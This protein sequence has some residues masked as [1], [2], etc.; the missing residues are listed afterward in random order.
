MAEFHDSPRLLYIDAYDSFA[1][2]IITFVKLRLN[3]SVE[4]I[5]IDDPRF[6]CE[7]QSYFQQYVQQFDAVIAGPGPGTPAKKEDIGLIS[8]LWILNDKSIVP[9]L[10]ICLG[11]QSLVLS[12]GGSVFRLPFPRHGV[13]TQ[14]VHSDRTI[15]KGIANIQA[16]LYNSLA[17]DLGHAR[18]RLQPLA[19][20]RVGNQAGLILSAVRHRDTQKPF[21]GLQFHPESACTNEA[22]A[23]IIQ[24][25]WREASEWNRT[26]RKTDVPRARIRDEAQESPCK[27]SGVTLSTQPTPKLPLSIRQ[28]SIPDASVTVDTLNGIA[29]SNECS[30][31]LLESVQR[32]PGVPIRTDTGRFTVAGFCNQ[33]TKRILYFT[34]TSQLEI[35]NGRDEIMDERHDID[36]WKYLKA[37]MEA[38]RPVNEGDVLSPFWGGLIGFISYE[39]ALKSI[40]IEGTASAAR[41]DVCFAFVERSIVIDHAEN[42][43]WIQSIKADDNG[44]IAE[45][46]E[47]IRA[48]QEQ[49]FTVSEESSASLNVRNIFRHEKESYIESVRQCKEE[50]RAGNSYELCLTTESVF[51]VSAPISRS[52]FS[53]LLYRRL[54]DLNGAPFATYM[55]FGIDGNDNAVSIIGSSPERFLN[56]DRKG[57]C[58]FRP[59]KGTLKK[60]PDMSLEKAEEFFKSSKERAE[61]LMIVDLV[62]HDLNEVLQ[63]GEAQVTKLMGVEEYAT[64]YQ[65]VSVVEGDFSSQTDRTTGLD[66]LATSLPPGSMTGAP[67]K[68]SCE[69]LHKI[70]RNRERG[71]YSGVL[72]Y[73]DVG[74]G[75]DFSVGIR[76]AFSWDQHR[77]DGHDTW[78]I[79][80]GGAITAQSDEEAEYAEMLTKLQAVL[81]IF[82]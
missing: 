67:K 47:A 7:N 17:V 49:S 32:A 58:Q 21:W 36:L 82:S 6:S 4:I 64:V 18:G 12:H 19:W 51:S 33:E 15:F 27:G 11:F 39:A 13:V 70:E 55:R 54:R 22:G 35:R 16:T 2:N 76:L 46:Q 68:R 29:G 23:K 38:V 37:F 28:I 78:H 59:I 56:W 72:G 42:R 31:L 9:I 41:P 61:N 30:L 62:R 79:G 45:M 57:H 75:G 53:W 14:V 65:L 69:L 73:L 71:I 60:T 74:G 34:R 77:Q 40:N 25:W 20:H 81:G 52:K 3:A 66:V 43:I 24:N 26:H 1:H 48:A 63:S 44:W 5:R 80:A 8:Q 50:I 10:G